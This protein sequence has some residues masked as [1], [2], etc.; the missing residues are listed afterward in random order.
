MEKYVKLKEDMNNHALRDYPREAV[1]II[2]KDLKYIP[3]NNIS[4]HP[5]STFWLDPKALVEHDDNIWGFFHSHPGAENPIP[6]NE[7]KVGAALQEYKFLVGFN[8]KFYIYWYNNNVDALMFD[9]FQEKHL[10]SNN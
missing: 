1:G 9:D 4:E 7:V 5:L 8:N 6:S 10:V 2:T 3:C